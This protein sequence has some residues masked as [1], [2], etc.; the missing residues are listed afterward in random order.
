MVLAQKV[1]TFI[2]DRYSALIWIN[3]AEWEV[4]CSSL[5]FCQ[6][7]EKGGFPAVKRIQRKSGSTSQIYMGCA[8]HLFTIHRVCT[9]PTLGKPT[10]PILREVPNRPMIGGCFGASPFFGGICKLTQVAYSLTLE[11]CEIFDRCTCTRTSAL[12]M[13]GSDCS[14]LLS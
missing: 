9:H 12:V 13:S 1:K 11:K 6:H 3:R 10:I 4:L 8:L 14:V 7:V 5:A 2:W